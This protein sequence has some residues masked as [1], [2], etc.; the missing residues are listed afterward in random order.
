MRIVNKIGLEAEFIL[1]NEKDEIV[2]PGYY[3][4]STD[5]FIILGEFR[6][7]PGE[8]RGETIGNF[9]K[10]LIETRR[11]A[12]KN[13]LHLDFGYNE[14]TPEFKAKIL[15]RMGTK[16]IQSCLNL[17]GKD[18]L[19]MSDNI[20]KDGVIVKVK[21]STGLHIHFS[22]AVIH[23]WKDKDGN[24]CN[25]SLKL[26]KERDIKNIIKKM[27]TNILPNYDLGVKL[28]YRNPGFYEYKTWG[29][30]YRSLPT[31]IKILDFENL[32]KVVDYSFSL[33]EKLD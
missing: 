11:K 29:F 2:Y 18:I 4:F 7:E 30:E 1:R 25:S 27:D 33:L 6:G 20:V 10:E 3:A 16:L 14:I 13:K 15:R 5:E 8:T 28:K 17:Y 32:V 19:S 23:K 24:Q 22:K 26:L 21:I 31:C 12:K 9:F